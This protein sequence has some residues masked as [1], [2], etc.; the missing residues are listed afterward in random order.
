MQNSRT[1]ES[2][3]VGAQSWVPW[4]MV[5]ARDTRRAAPAT[6]RPGAP[7]A[8]TAA[9]PR[10]APPAPVPGRG[11]RSV[12]GWFSSPLSSPC[13]RSP[14][15]IVSPQ[16]STGTSKSMI[17]GMPCETTRPAAKSWKPGTRRSIPA[18]SRTPPSVTMPAAPRM[19]QRPRGHVAAEAGAQ[20]VMPDVLDHVHARL[21]RRGDP[22]EQLGEPVR[23]RIGRRG[24]VRDRRER[25]ADQRRPLR[26]Q[27]FQVQGRVAGGAVAH[28]EPLDRV[29]HRR[30]VEPL[31]RLYRPFA[32]RS[33]H[34][35]PLGKR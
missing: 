22:L 26:E 14:G 9:P 24:G 20:P 21:R 10:P 16:I 27:A 11:R 35:E 25:I 4:A 17:A 19:L 31:Q 12:P 18:R 7:A 15:L 6:T 1:C 13:S 30:A 3:R 2:V 8:R 5:S 34:C 33:S 29:H 28:R 23:A 32:H